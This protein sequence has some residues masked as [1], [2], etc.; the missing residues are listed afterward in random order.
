MPRRKKW[1]LFIV[2]LVLAVIVSGPFLWWYA[3]PVRPLQV[4][5]LDK[6]VPDRTYREH[7]GLMWILNHRKRFNRNT[8]K[9]FRYDRDYYGFFPLEGKSFDIISLPSDLKKADMVY[10]ADTYGV[11]SE[12]FYGENL[13]GERSELLYGGMT[14]EEAAA[15]AAAARAGVLTVAEFNT[16][17]SP[18]PEGAR[19]KMEEVFGVEFTGWTGRYFSDLSATNKEMP[20]WL[21]ASYERQEGKKWRYTGPG[22]VLVHAGGRVVVLAEGREVETPP[23]AAMVRRPWPRGP[24]VGKKIPYYYWF[25]ILR[26]KKGSEVWAEFQINATAEG[27]KILAHNGI[28]ASFPAVVAVTDRPVYYLAGDFADLAEVPPRWSVAGMSWVQRL[29]GTALPGDQTY[30]YWHFYFPLVDFF[31]EKIGDGGR[32]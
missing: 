4:I 21:V 12:D 2:P 5:I 15:V 10:I 28:P 8:G 30:F 23:C 11:Y 22:L 14:E 31:L 19:K 27:K 17:A 18:T 6:T 3:L 13:P 25:E 26:P 7:R 20:E 1:Y 29:F 16:L 32:R 24:E 9:P